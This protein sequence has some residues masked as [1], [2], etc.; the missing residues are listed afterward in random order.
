M[1]NISAFFTLK[2][3]NLSSLLHQGLLWSQTTPKQLNGSSI[4]E[5]GCAPSLANPTGKEHLEICCTTQ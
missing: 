3:E 1:M 2:K 5:H 4:K